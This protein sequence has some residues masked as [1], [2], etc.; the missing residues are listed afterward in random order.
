MSIG[1]SL[2]SSWKWFI[3]SP[4]EFIFN[5]LRSLSKSS[6]T[7]WLIF[8]PWFVKLWSPVVLSLPTPK[9][10]FCCHSFKKFLKLII[11]VEIPKQGKISQTTVVNLSVDKLFPFKPLTMLSPTMITFPFTFIDL[12]FTFHFLLVL[13]MRCF[14]FQ[15]LWVHW[16]Y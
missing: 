13:S 11:K 6:D 1:D 12:V 7:F 14:R 16:W 3:F 9:S 4:S 15:L 8:C 10:E 2:H 5:F